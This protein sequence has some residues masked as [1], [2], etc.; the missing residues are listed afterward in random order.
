MSLAACLYDASQG[1]TGSHQTVDIL[2]QLPR[3]GRQDPPVDAS[4][5]QPRPGLFGLNRTR[6]LLARDVGLPHSFFCKTG[7]GL[8]AFSSGGMPLL[9]LVMAAPGLAWGQGTQLYLK[10][11]PS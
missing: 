9:F 4:Q 11:G 6:L 10:V 5:K 8:L 2:Q 7:W 1:T 3:V